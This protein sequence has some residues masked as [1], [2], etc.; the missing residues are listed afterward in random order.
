MIWVSLTFLAAFIW[1]LTDLLGKFVVDKEEKDTFLDSGITGLSMSALFILLP[2]AWGKVEIFSPL[3]PAIAAGGFYVLALASYYSGMS[4]EEVSRFSPTLS[5]STVFIAILAFLI[6]GEQFTAPVYLGI[7]STVLG[8]FL[9]S[10]DDPQKS[11]E[12]M[13]SRKAFYLA[14][15]A[16]L[17]FALRDISLKLA[18]NQISFWSIPFWIGT[19][20][21]V[22]SLSFLIGKKPDLRRKE[23]GRGHLALMGLL[24]AAGY[25]VFS[26]AVSIGPVSLASAVLRVK[27]FL[28]FFLS[29]VI[30]RLHPEIIQEQLNK[31]TI[32]QKAVATGLIFS[33][34]I[35]I[36]LFF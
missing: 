22:V 8:A 27:V 5:V 16:A 33:G 17:L 2:L 23:N 18:S 26:R 29:T 1:T 20:S 21:L 14:A 6:L 31:K 11:L 19:G 10:L 35:L 36:Q 9:I 24:S 15:L 30:A 7:I 12:K 4:K 32:L 25:F 28:V 13:T 3:L 34:V